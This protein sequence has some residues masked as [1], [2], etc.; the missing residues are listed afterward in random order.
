MAGKTK[1]QNPKA[2]RQRSVI[3]ITGVPGSGKTS[4]AGELAKLCGAKALAINDLV[5]S[6]GIFSEV[7]VTDGA[8]IVLLPKLQQALKKEISSHK[9][10][11][12]IEGHLAC[13]IK[14]PAGFVLICRCNPN[15]LRSRLQSRGYSTDKIKA[16]V[17]SEMLDYC[18][19]QCS[20]RYP[21]SRTFE[22]DTS[23][24]SPRECAL[25]ALELFHGKG[26]AKKR[27]CVNWSGMLFA[28]EIDFRNLRQ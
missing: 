11:L 26:S 7:D 16:N 12:I 3:I 15:V 23:S 2:A 24:K 21:S 13:E 28:Q 17:L 18:T 14:L 27:E 8:K 22:I 19:L 4:I 10:T 9:G 5:A 1:T 25:A 20:K 6:Q